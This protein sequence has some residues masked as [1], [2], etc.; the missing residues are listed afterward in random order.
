MHR[1]DRRLGSV[2]LC[3]RSSP[4]MFGLTRHVPVLVL[5]L[6]LVAAA[7]ADD[8]ADAEPGPTVAPSTTVPDA[9]GDGV[10]G[11]D[12]VD[13]RVD[14]VP[15]ATVTGPVSSTNPPVLPQPAVALPEGYVEDEFFIGGEAI[16]YAAVGEH[17]ADGLWDVESDG[18]ADF[19][20]RILV[21]RPPADRFSG[22]VVVEWLN[23]SAVESSPDWGYLSEEIGASGHGYVA[24]SVQA[25]GVIGGEPI[26]T[27]EVDEE[28]AAEA[29]AD[30]DDADTGGLVNIDP[31]RYGTLVHPGDAYAYDIF[32]HVGRVLEVDEGGVLG[33]LEATTLLALGESQ[34][35][36]FLTTYVNAV[37]PTVD[38]FDAFLVHS[39]GA[40]GAPLGGE[41]GDDTSFVDRGARIRTDL[42]E[43]VFMVEAETDLT[44]LGYHL[45]RQPDT[46][47]IR[48]WELAGTAHADAHIIRAILGGSRDASVGSFLGCADPINTGPHH[49]G[50]QA[51]LRRLVE[52]VEEGTA[53]PAGE[54]I[55]TT[56]SDPVAIVRDELGFALGG[57][58]NPLVDVPVVV[59][60][61][62]PWTDVDLD[63]D[64]SLD[65][66]ALFG[67]TLPIE[68][69]GLTELHGS[70][71]GYVAA[72]DAAATAAVS[73]GFLLDYDAEQLRR[74]AAANQGLFG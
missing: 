39:R 48:T 51:A 5:A 59:T 57:V 14:P 42:D 28:T 3:A 47:S 32:T 56:D 73:A 18:R 46:D 61:G 4:L 68:P 55:M 10:D 50:V 12:G 62:D 29:G 1:D 35:A 63:S 40:G 36:G 13:D 26:L 52:W 49:E 38:V 44:V 23:V 21:R 24:V 58:R 11:V 22:T 20:T 33:G 2:V 31:E 45:A 8:E 69:T 65:V 15:T 72:F 30:P 19:R 34:S 9:V 27:V 64:E 17:G 71:E 70:P 43:P 74:E 53:P 16:R 54:R 66:C 37:H 6:G 67:Q 41:F 25:L 7:C 60:T